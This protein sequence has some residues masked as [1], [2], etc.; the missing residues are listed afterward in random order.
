MFPIY[1]KIIYTRNALFEKNSSLRMSQ[2]K[3][4]KYRSD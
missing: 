2:R 1:T 4:S 3:N